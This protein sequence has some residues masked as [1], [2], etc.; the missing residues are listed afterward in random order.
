M[1]L[2]MSCI[3]ENRDILN[4]HLKH[5]LNATHI[6]RTCTTFQYIESTPFNCIGKQFVALTCT[7]II[8]SD[9]YLHFCRITNEAPTI[10]RQL[11]TKLISDL[12]MVLSYI[13][14]S[15][16]AITTILVFIVLLVTINIIVTLIF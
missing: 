5:V 13:I 12:I 11:K 15:I 4:I 16:I 7:I 14:T 1:K 10:F 8:S 6:L 2:Y 3:D 9:K